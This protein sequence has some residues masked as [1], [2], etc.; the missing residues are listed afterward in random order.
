MAPVHVD[1]GLDAAQRLLREH[2]RLEVLPVADQHPRPG[3]FR[4]RIVSSTE[5]LALMGTF[6]KPPL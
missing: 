1:E 2:H 5:Y 3:S 6:T 4:I